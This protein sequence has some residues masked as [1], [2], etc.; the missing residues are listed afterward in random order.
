[1]L[2]FFLKN[3]VHKIFEITVGKNII[4]LL[5]SSDN[6]KLLSRFGFTLVVFR[7]RRWKLLTTIFSNQF[8]TL[9]DPNIHKL[10]FVTFL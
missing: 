2:K 6:N 3:T 9:N 5:N 4:I 8:Y 1:M 10:E 7:N